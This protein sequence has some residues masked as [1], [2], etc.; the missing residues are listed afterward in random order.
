MLC[1][2]QFNFVHC[3]FPVWKVKHKLYVKI[4]FIL[5]KRGFLNINFI[6]CNFIEDSP[7]CL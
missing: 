6:E 7:L 4:I 5:A 3:F 1:L 2:I